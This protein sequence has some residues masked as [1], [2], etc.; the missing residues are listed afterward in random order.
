MA[1]SLSGQPLAGVSVGLAG[2][3]GGTATDALGNFRLSGVAAGTYTLR[4]GALGYR[5]LNLPVTLA[6]GE[7]RPRFQVGATAENLLNVEWNQAQ[8]ATQTRLLSPRP[9]LPEGFDELHFTPGAPFYL[10]LNASL[11]F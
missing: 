10:K 8:F 3:P 9:E 5:A 11:F 6:A 1:D 2:Q 7:T 4:V